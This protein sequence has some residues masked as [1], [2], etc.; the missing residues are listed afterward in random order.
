[1]KLST[2]NSIKSNLKTNPSYPFGT[3]QAFEKYSLSSGQVNLKRLAKD[4]LENRDVNTVRV[5]QKNLPNG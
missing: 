2:L 3:Y 4:L 5:L 1:M